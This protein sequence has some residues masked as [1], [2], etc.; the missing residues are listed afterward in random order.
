MSAPK[1]SEIDV[2]LELE[3]NWDGYGAPMIDKKALEI[4]KRIGATLSE[5]EW[6]AVPT[7][8]GGVQLEIH[9]LNEDIEIN[10]WRTA[11]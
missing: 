6:Y 8:D 9:L 5:Y 7:G 4:A 10:I 11:P 2:L 3:P 1:L